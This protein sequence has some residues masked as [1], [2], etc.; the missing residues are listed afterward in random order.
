M[1][2]AGSNR[3]APREAT[4]PVHDDGEVVDLL[5][6]GPDT[7]EQP[8]IHGPSEHVAQPFGEAGHVRPMLSTVPPPLTCSSPLGEH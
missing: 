1:P 4:I 6:A 5:I 7:I 3:L 2:G 8:F